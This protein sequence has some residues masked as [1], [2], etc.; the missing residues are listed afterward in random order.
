MS[1]LCLKMKSLNSAS[2]STDFWTFIKINRQKF[3][4]IDLELERPI[5]FSYQLKAQYDACDLANDSSRTR[6]QGA[7]GEKTTKQCLHA[8]PSSASHERKSCTPPT[9]PAEW[10]SARPFS[11]A[12]YQPT[13]TAIQQLSRRLWPPI[14]QQP[15]RSTRACPTGSA[16]MAFGSKPYVHQQQP[17]E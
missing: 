16:T 5:V 2:T 7:E 15:V 8:V 9:S 17:A 11:A 3:S 1:M 6:Q 14:Q 13:S 4:D 12:S 10:Q